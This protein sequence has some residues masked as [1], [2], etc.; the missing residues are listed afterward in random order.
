MLS[1]L[2]PYFYLVEAML[3]S[4]AGGKVVSVEVQSLE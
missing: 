4:R 1:R 2:P 3:V